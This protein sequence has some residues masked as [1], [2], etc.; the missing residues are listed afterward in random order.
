MMTLSGLEVVVWWDKGK[1]HWLRPIRHWVALVVFRQSSV[2]HRW[3]TSELMDD[4]LSFPS[5]MHSRLRIDQSTPLGQVPKWLA[6][7]S[8]NCFVLH[9]QIDGN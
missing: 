8:A 3:R 6:T 1:L 2:V 5:Y 9:E 7:D 4:L